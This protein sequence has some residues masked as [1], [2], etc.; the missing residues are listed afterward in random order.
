MV[1]KVNNLMKA[2]TVRFKR[3]IVLLLIFAWSLWGITL[4]NQIFLADG[5]SAAYA[6]VEN[7]TTPETAVQKNQLSAGGTSNFVYLP[8]IENDP[9]LPAGCV[10]E[11]NDTF[12]TAKGFLRREIEYCGFLDDPYDFYTFF[13]TETTPIRIQLENQAPMF[14]HQPTWPP[15]NVLVLYSEN[16]VPMATCCSTA[17][18]S[19]SLEQELNAGEYYISVYAID[20]N[21][22]ISYTVMISTD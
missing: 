18:F 1:N 8:L 9:F 3:V 10:S 19:L 14:P 5:T 7:T 22:G 15:N 4:L 17:K 2:E 13:L 16:K 11:D 21:S 12:A 6:F 20:I